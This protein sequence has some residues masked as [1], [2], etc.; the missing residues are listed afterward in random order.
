M[1]KLSFSYIIIQTE[2]SVELSEAAEFGT[3]RFRKLAPT[4]D[5]EGVWRVGSRMKNRVPFTKDS[6]MPKILPTQ[7]KVTLLIMRFSHEF[8]HAGQDG[9]LSRFRMLGFWAVRAGIL[10]KSVKQHCVT[11]R[12][13]SKTLLHQ[14]LGQFPDGLFSNPVAWGYVQFDLFGPYSC[15]GD[16]NARTTKKTWGMI[17]VDCNSGAV[18]LDIVQDY[19]THAVLLS[20][21]R[22]GSLRGW[23][24]IIC[25]DPGSQLESASGKLENW[26][27]AMGDSLR[28][29][30]TAKNF[31]WEIS[32]PDSPWRQGKAERLIATVKKQVN[33]SLGDT[34]VT[35]V[36]LQ[37]ILMEV[38]NMC[39][40][41]PIGLSKPREDGIY[42]IITPN[43]LL[44]GR[45]TNI[46]PDDTELLDDLPM[47]ARY[48][49]V[50][51]VTT[52]FWSKWAAEVSPGLVNRPTW[53]K[54][55]RNLCV[56]DVVLICQSTAIKGKYR[57][58][59]VEEVKVSDDACVRSV[60]LRYA[61]VTKD[62]KPRIIHVRRS[63]QRLA[64]IL[65]V[66][67]QSSPVKVEEHEHYVQCCKAL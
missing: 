14:P 17:I 30:G 10:A 5:E 23:P 51:H 2:I 54:K 9:T 39:N 44:L 47:N 49:I 66:E 46:L 40:E 50:H 26:W 12:K 22:F 60:L 58:A 20:L 62:N 48:R 18:H 36:E 63:V 11:C 35:P 67:E 1:L 7:H 31:K 32:P 42:N 61:V 24:G 27:V 56:N 65:P 19:S 15:R 43:Q 28:T 16:V 64:L 38:A 33:I 34:R 6:K 29:Y 13:I 52:S 4:L 45:S 3:G 53:H 21:R 57:L 59:V 41:R 8:C 55:G 37:T 25:S